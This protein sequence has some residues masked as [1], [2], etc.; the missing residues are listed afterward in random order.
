MSIFRYI[1]RSISFYRKQHLALFAGTLI[2]TAVLTG[3]LIVGDSVRLSLSK[4]VDVRLGN[5]RY[6][7]ITGERLVR[8]DLSQE[9]GKE[10]N[11]PT[12]S[13]LMVQGVASNPDNASRANGIHVIGVDNDFW[14][15]SGIEVDTPYD[16]EVIINN[17]VAKALNLAEGD[18]FLLRVKKLDAIPLNAPFGLG[19]KQL[20]LIMIWGVLA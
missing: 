5:I 18:E 12:A 8:W 17:D 11:A 7:L 3:A 9:L 4:L 6:A 15:L 2:S 20:P 16:N 14:K 13:L 1:L 19:L 10:L